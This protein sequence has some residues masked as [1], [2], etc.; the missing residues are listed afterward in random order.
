VFRT[1][2]IRSDVNLI[3]V[4][5]TNGQEQAWWYDDNVCLVYAARDLL[6]VAELVVARWERGD[7][8]E[9]VRK[10][11]AAMM[12]LPVWTILKVSMLIGCSS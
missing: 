3:T 8:A 7:L 9:A 6:A 2:D 10:L 11:S 5:D 12:G 4:F 1:Y